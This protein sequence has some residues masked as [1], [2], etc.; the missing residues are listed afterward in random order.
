[1]DSKNART[2]TQQP[3]LK[4]TPGAAMAATPSA[5]KISNT[6]LYIATCACNLAAFSAGNALTWSSP[7]ISKL[8]KVGAIQLEQESWV[9]STIALGAS[10]GPFVAGA[11]VDRIGRKTT[12]LLTSVMFL[13]SWAL[14]ATSFSFAEINYPI[15]YI[16]RV[17]AG[18]SAG[19]TYTAAPMYVA[20][21]AEDSVRGALG[22]VLAFFLC[23]G[24][25]L[26]YI[27]GPNTSFMGLILASAAA[28]I[29]FAVSFFFMPESPYYL[30]SKNEKAKAMRALQ[31]IRGV[32]DA[33]YIQKE[34]S[35]IQSSVS[36]AATQ[37]SGITEL[38]ATK[39][40]IKALYLSCGLVAFQQL[41]GINV[42]LFYS[43]PIFEATGASLDASVC[44][45]AVG[46]VM[47]FAAGIA[48]PLAKCLGMKMLLI[49]SAIGMAI[50]QGVLGLFFFIKKNNPD[51]DIPG[52]NLLPLGSMVI[53]IITYCLGFGPLPWAVMGEMFP[54]NIKAIAS[55]VT[56]SFCW[57]LG[58]IMTKGF[59]SVSEMLGT[60]MAF[61]IFAGFCLVALAFTVILLPD[62]RGMSLQEI[63]DLLNGRIVNRDRKSGG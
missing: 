9:G 45:I 20:E 5:G 11:L 23:A 17:I 62:T 37:K 48:P 4:G 18:M 22:S 46:A 35:E 56:A 3:L 13:A 12:L 55:A 42:V 14:I 58:F 31:W 26:E 7:T 47:V 34:L 1:M 27:V 32:S 43:E 24:F 21:I 49:I 44:S 15:I 38:I 28:P 52:W 30:I 54:A 61:W 57:I 51:I 39:G 10:V 29:V 16:A 60:D 8:Q 63:Q 50:C 59:G 40:N 6:N 25:L 2:D 36:E 41:S 53:Y 33:N 19:I